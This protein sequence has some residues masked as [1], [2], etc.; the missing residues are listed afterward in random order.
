MR[1][2]VCSTHRA[3]G[4]EVPRLGPTRVFSVQGVRF[5]FASDDVCVHLLLLTGSW[6]HSGVGVVVSTE[7]ATEVDRSSVWTFHSVC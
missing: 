7:C 5:V 4:E 3:G 6:L 1:S 2:P